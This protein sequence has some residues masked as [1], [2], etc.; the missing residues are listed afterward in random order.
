MQGLNSVLLQGTANSIL[1]LES[2]AALALVVA[3]GC[4]L[5]SVGASGAGMDEP[6]LQQPVV[7]IGVGLGQRFCLQVGTAGSVGLQLGTA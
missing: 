5:R 3:Q 6:V 7:G 4:D 2:T 1:L